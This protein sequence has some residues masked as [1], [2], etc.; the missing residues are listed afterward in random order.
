MAVA[1]RQVSNWGHD[2]RGGLLARPARR[3]STLAEAR[4]CDHGRPNLGLGIG[5]NTAVFSAIDAIL[6]RPLP[7]PSSDR[8]VVLTQ[9]QGTSAQTGISIPRLEDWNRLSSRFEAISGFYAE[10][11]SDTTSELPERMRRAQVMPRFLEVWGVNPELGR[12]FA[13]AEHHQGGPAVV[14]ISHR[15]WRERLG[16]EANVLQRA[17]RIEGQLHQIAGVMPRSFLFPDRAVDL[18]VPALVDGPLAQNPQA[19][20]LVW[21][22]AIGRMRPDTT[23]EQARADLNRVQSQLG[24]QYPDTDRGIDVGVAP[25]RSGSSVKSETPC[26]CCSVPSASC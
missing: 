25:L 2:V 9:T 13:D 4:F 26:G 10:D 3:T 12:T 1:T 7:F 14:L 8:L 15:Y 21:Y 16:G 23:F 18:W 11:V 6:L 17:V 22:S 20:P 24:D 5:A 19:R